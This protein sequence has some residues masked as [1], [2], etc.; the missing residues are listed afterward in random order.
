MEGRE[1]LILRQK[2]GSLEEMG[3]EL[4]LEQV[5]QPQK[6]QQKRDIP[7]QGRVGVGEIPKVSIRFVLEFVSRPSWIP[8]QKSEHLNF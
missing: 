5:L 7:R 3:F 2:K 4:R 6:K 8:R 1:N